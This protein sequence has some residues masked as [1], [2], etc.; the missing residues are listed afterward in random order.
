MSITMPSTEQRLYDAADNA[1]LSEGGYLASI[2]NDLAQA[3]GD[4]AAAGS[5][6]GNEPSPRTGPSRG[7]LV[8]MGRIGPFRS[9]R[10][11]RYTQ[12]SHEHLCDALVRAWSAAK[13]P[14]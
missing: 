4:I 12:R 13:R 5:R 3:A 10:V 2:G 1:Y 11:Y 8:L 14:H 7:D 9:G 6:R